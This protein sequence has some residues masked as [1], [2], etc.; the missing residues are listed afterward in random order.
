MSSGIAN[1]TSGRLLRPR[2]EPSPGWPLLWLPLLLFAFEGPPGM[3]PALIRLAVLLLLGMLAW[4][5]GRG[6]A[7]APAERGIAGLLLL[8]WFIVAGAAFRLHGVP[9]SVP[10]RLAVT[11]GLLLGPV[12]LLW[13]W[14]RRARMV[15]AASPS[16]PGA[17]RGSVAAPWSALALVGGALFVLDRLVGLPGADLLVLGTVGLLWGA[18]RVRGRRHGL[19]VA[20]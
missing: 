14:R 1:D 4:G 10:A 13:A 17:G 3:G 19:G 5:M 18:L 9:V 12:L 7:G 2:P 6:P 20:R 16:G 8:A 15:P 11:A